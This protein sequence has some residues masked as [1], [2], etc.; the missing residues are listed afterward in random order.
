MTRDLKWSPATQFLMLNSDRA[1]C[2]LSFLC[3]SQRIV[4]QV[5][6]FDPFCSISGIVDNRSSDCVIHPRA[7]RAT[8]QGYVARNEKVAGRRRS[9]LPICAKYRPV[10]RQMCILDPCLNIRSGSIVLA[11]STGDIES[12][13]SVI[14]LVLSIWCEG[15]LSTILG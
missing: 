3:K 10:V 2:P 1:I 8:S 11:T 4:P 5:H 12:G 6:K 14:L 15:A 7:A 13:L 9:W